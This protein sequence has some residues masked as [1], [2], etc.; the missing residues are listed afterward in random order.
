[1]KKVIFS[2]LG[3]MP[4]YLFSQNPIVD[5]VS[6]SAGYANQVWYSLVNDEVKSTSK[7]NWD[8]AFEIKGFYSSILA[9]TQKTG[10][11][12]YQSPF[13]FGEWSSFDTSGYASWTAL[14]NSD[15]A[16]ELGA[17]N[18]SGVFNTADMGW[19][20]YDPNTHA[21]V[22]TRLFLLVNS[23]NE[24][25]KLGINSLVSGTYKFT[26]MNIDQSDSNTFSF[27]KSDYSNSQFAYF[28]M[29]SKTI[30]ER[31]PDAAE[32]DLT[33]TKYIYNNY[34]DGNG[35]FIQYPV[36]GVLSNKKIEIAEVKNVNVNTHTDY[37][38]ANY[39]ENINVIGSDWKTFNG[40]QFVIKDSLVYF[41]KD[42][43]DNVWKLV[44]T[45]FTGSS[46]G[47]YIFS[48]QKLGN[49][50]IKEEKAGFFSALYPNPCQNGQTL[51]L[52]TDFK[53]AV[54]S[55]NIEIKDM[56]GKTVYT[57]T[58]ENINGFNAYG[59]P[60]EFG[61]GVYT[62]CVTA[63]QKVSISKLIIN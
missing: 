37:Q 55:Y 16:W 5:T 50:S 22:G 28:D 39:S 19:G 31:E 14:H 26:Y 61:P 43:N 40:M 8:L 15:T 17:L 53:N 45:G 20:E 46:E 18:R 29:S 7:D 32:W 41:A 1:M 33:F 13:S 4:F 3:L 54:E 60:V 57:H 25:Y 52:V 56:Q 48:K 62:V 49:T 24:F 30:F 38:S 9:N 58:F 2:I 27:K 21:I 6:T 12:V 59:I 34:P 35:G 47:K 11:K 10:L 44:F 23:N 63:D 42:L 36:T 51:H